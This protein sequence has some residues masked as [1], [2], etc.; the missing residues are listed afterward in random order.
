MKNDNRGF[1]LVEL[2]VSIAIFSIVML[3]AFS[4]MVSGARTFSNVNSR[5]DRQLKAQLALSHISDTLMNSSSGVCVRDGKVYVLNDSDDGVGYTV[6]VYGLDETSHELRYGTETQKVAPTAVSADGVTTLTYTTAVTPVDR[7][8]AGVE[9]FT[10]TL[11][12]EDTAGKTARSATI[13]IKFLNGSQTYTQ[14][15]ALRND[16]QVVKV[17]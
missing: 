4:F 7:L 17:A 13:A 15:A 3:M 2:I 6:Q 10:V 5:I 11:S 14:T 1:T 9:S 12:P 16:P 8:A